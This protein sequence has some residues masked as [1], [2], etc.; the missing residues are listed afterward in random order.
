MGYSLLIT[1]PLENLLFSKNEVM[2]NET[3]SVPFRAGKKG[4]AFV[5]PECGDE[6]QASYSSS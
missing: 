3:V 1:M 5:K 4:T 6:Q 2:K